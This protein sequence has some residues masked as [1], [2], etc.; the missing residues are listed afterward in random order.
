MRDCVA[1][2][3]VVHQVRNGTMFPWD[4][5]KSSRSS[6]SAVFVRAPEGDTSGDIYLLSCAHVVNGANVDGGVKLTLSNDPNRQIPVRVRK[7]CPPH[8]TAVLTVSD[9]ASKDYLRPH[10][11]LANVGC[12]RAPCAGDLFKAYGFTLGFPMPQQ[13]EFQLQWRNSQQRGMLQFNGTANPGM[14]GG[15][16]FN[17]KDELVSLI[18]A[19]VAQDNV[20]NVVLTTPASHLNTV[21]QSAL[22]EPLIMYHR[23]L[24]FSF[25]Q[26]NQDF[27][28]LYGIQNEYQGVQLHSVDADRVKH[29][30]KDGD[31]LVA[32]EDPKT[33][34]MVPIS[35]KGD[36]R[37]DTVKDW[38]V[39]VDDLVNQI[40]RDQPMR[41][42]VMRIN[43]GVIEPVTID[44]ADEDVF[45]NAARPYNIMEKRD[46]SS[47]GFVAEQP[48]LSIADRVPAMRRQTLSQRRQPSLVVTSMYPGSQFAEHTPLKPGHRLI[49]VNNRSVSTVEELREAFQH[50]IVG[51]DGVQYLK[52]K[53]DCGT[54]CLSTSVVSYDKLMK[55]IP[56]L[57]SQG[58]PV[59]APEVMS[60]APAAD[61]DTP[62]T[63]ISVASK[64]SSKQSDL[65]EISSVALSSTNST[66]SR[67]SVPVARSTD[68]QTSL[69]PPSFRKL[70]IKIG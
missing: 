5:G 53:S 38:P 9:Q 51:E 28:S 52:I 8:D 64:A 69:E 15:G 66:L 42:T 40:P 12:D 60:L 27:N 61:N 4:T 29:E 17:E 22:D 26:S 32:V 43:D 6:G 24:P 25:S 54:D 59:Q 3:N 16:V 68:I 11:K 14:S 50:P 10:I 37:L 48:T 56:L 55:E 7:V 21:L 36:L 70:G 58:V 19:K 20:D 62:D 13:S 41:F 33:S 67:L 44:V 31:V 1:R 57:E 45:Q 30:F 34:Q 63:E 18:R 46:F 65:S 35:F 47:F 2:L 39:S 23:E 49:N